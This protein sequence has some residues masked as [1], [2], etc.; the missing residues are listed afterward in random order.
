MPGTTLQRPRKSAIPDDGHV[1]LALAM[2]AT[3]K[4]GGQR[5]AVDWMPNPGRQAEAFNSE[6][7][8]LGYGGGAGGGVDSLL[9]PPALWRRA[10]SA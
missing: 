10:Y 4:R 3:G 8:V 7:D 1:A 5:Q 6:A 9:D 2:H